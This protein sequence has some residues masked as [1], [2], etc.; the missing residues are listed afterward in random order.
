M[1]MDLMFSCE[2]NRKRAK[3]LR[4]LNFAQ[5]EI[6]GGNTPSLIINTLKDKNY[7]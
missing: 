1:K 5:H 2:N 6:D 7:E 4:D 3:F